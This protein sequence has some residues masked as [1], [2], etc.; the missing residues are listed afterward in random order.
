VAQPFSA[1]ELEAYL[2]ES[3]PP[4]KLA[5]LETALRADPELAR[6]LAAAVGRRDAGVHSL[7][8][9]WRRERLTCPSREQ[10]GSYLLGVLEPSWEDYVRFHLEQIGCRYCLANLNDLQARQAA[11]MD[12]ADAQRRRRYF[13][14][15]AGLLRSAD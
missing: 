11:S 8:A 10:L 15:S 4:A 3:L 2:D 5:A 7:G 6:A 9:V 1:G 14:S 13:Q 12:P